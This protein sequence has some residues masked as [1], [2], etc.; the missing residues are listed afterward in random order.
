MNI[1]DIIKKINILD[2]R[3]KCLSCSSSGGAITSVFGRVGVVTAANNDYTWGQIDKTV[4]SLADITTRTH[5]LLSGLSTDDHTQYGLLAGRTGGQ[6]FIGGTAPTDDLI[7]RATSGVGTAGSLISFQVG[8]NGASE[9]MRILFDKK[10]LF[11]KAISHFSNPLVEIDNYNSG[12]GGPAV[13]V[14]TNVSMN[15]AFTVSTMAGTSSINLGWSGLFPFNNELN[16]VNGQAAPNIIS[17]NQTL[18]IKSTI[19]LVTFS[20]QGTNAYASV[21]AGTTSHAQL[22][23]DTSV[24]PTTP[25]NGDVWFDGT[26]LKIRIGGITRTVTVT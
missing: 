3:I 13:M 26:D 1:E 4:S 23:L 25:S 24:A 5:S 9:A 16:F 10:V 15:G 8:N 18:Q 14:H 2:K 22:N 20:N 11:N 21:A 17:F 6:T 7:L 12:S 19:P